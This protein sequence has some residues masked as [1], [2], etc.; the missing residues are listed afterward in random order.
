VGDYGDAKKSV[1]AY[2]FLNAAVFVEPYKTHTLTVTNADAACTYAW[3]IS[4]SAL[5]S[6]LT[7]AGSAVQATVAGV[8]L[9]SLNVAESCDASHSLG[10]TLTTDLWAKYALETRVF[11]LPACAHTA[12]P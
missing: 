5:P 12:C 8:G 6:P 3:T 2:P 4:G 1:L 9:F 7:Y 11:P 10:R